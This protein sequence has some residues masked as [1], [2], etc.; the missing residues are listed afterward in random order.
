MV[1]YILGENEEYE[2]ENKWKNKPCLKIQ[3]K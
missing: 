2:A 1:E 3:K